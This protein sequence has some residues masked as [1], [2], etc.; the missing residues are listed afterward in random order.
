MAR[1]SI[2]EKTEIEVFEEFRKK[3]SKTEENTLVEKDRLFEMV[4]EVGERFAIEGDEIEYLIIIP[5]VVEK[6]A[7]TEKA[8]I[9]SIEKNNVKEGFNRKLKDYYQAARNYQC[10]LQ[11]VKSHAQLIY[12]EIEELS[13]FGR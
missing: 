6:L 9:K 7:K 11:T 3:L 8:V 5:E 10:E 13:G 2:E 12:Q 4:S 1:L